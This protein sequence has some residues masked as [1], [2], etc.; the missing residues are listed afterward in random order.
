MKLIRF[1]I[2]HIL[3]HGKNASGQT[4]DL[5]QTSALS[6]ESNSQVLQAIVKMLYLSRCIYIHFFAASRFF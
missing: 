4:A 3:M 6:F 2:K 5:R 1:Q